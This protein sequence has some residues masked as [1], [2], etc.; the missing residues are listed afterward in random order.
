MDPN[1]SHDFM[2]TGNTLIYAL[3]RVKYASHCN[4]DLKLV[5]NYALPDNQNQKQTQSAAPWAANV[6]NFP[7]PPAAIFINLPCE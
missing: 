1:S 6:S 4:K 2:Q 5:Q 3:F 7:E